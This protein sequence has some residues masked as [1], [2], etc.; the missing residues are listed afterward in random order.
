M[1]IPKKSPSLTLGVSVRVYFSFFSRNP[2]ICPVMET[3][4]SAGSTKSNKQNVHA[5][6]IKRLKE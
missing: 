6:H 3:H 5:P 4:I 1:L 2:P